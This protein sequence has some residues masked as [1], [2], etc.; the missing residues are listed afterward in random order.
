M[1][2]SIYTDS[3]SNLLPPPHSHEIRKL[4]SNVASLIAAGEVI[5]RPASIVKELVENAV[6]AGASRIEISIENGGIDLIRVHDNGRGIPA[7]Q[8]P[9]AFVRHATS[10]LASIDDLFRIQTLGFRGEALA[11]M[12]SAAECTLTTRPADASHGHAVVA[13]YSGVSPLKPHPHP[14]GTTIEV[15]GLFDAI[16]ARKK[17]LGTSRAESMAIT[18]I[19]CRIAL[20]YPD[21]AFRLIADNTDKILTPGD[22]SPRSAFG[23]VHSPELAEPLLDFHSELNKSESPV[24]VSGLCSPPSVHKG[25]RSYIHILVNGRSIQS[26]PL[27]HAIE[28]TYSSLLPIGRHPCVLLNVTVQPDQIDVNIHP[29]KQEIK[30]ESE[31]EVVKATQLALGR[32]LSNASFTKMETAV[33]NM[34]PTVIMRD[35]FSQPTLRRYDST[36][37]L[38]E[39]AGP[40]PTSQISNLGPESEFDLRELKP[41]GQ[42]SLKYI[43]CETRHSLMLI[44]QHAA[45]ERA[46][47]ETLLADIATGNTRRQPLLSPIILNSTPLLH[48]L[49]RTEKTTISELGWDFELLSQHRILIREVPA[50]INAK[51]KNIEMM[52]RMVLE[53]QIAEE[54]LSRPNTFAAGL[55]CHSSIRAGDKLTRHDIKFLIER[56][57]QTDNPFTCAHGRPSV[58]EIDERFIDNQFLR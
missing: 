22:G 20:A 37:S 54:N 13:S 10:K 34:A 42:F 30:F 36:S 25:N 45:D 16:P 55:A 1:V 6:D 40:E 28:R 47:Y 41:I 31:S 4:D 12:A 24:S 15:R 33:T 46:R 27:L 26:K 11:S 29:A 50:L 57:A 51:N 5:E 18:K 48:D 7:D 9:L 38:E 32:T 56:L 44:D 17:F 8:M 58:I 19:V 43:L 21:I 52:W 3:G 49:A 35:V 14:V 23:A 39:R 2:A 53:E